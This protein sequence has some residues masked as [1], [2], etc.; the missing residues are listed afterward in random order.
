MPG[1]FLCGIFAAG[2]SLVT[3][4]V[5]VFARAALFSIATTCVHLE[6]AGRE[7]IQGL[8][9]GAGVSCNLRFGEV[10]MIR[11]IPRRR[12]L[13]FSVLLAALLSSGAA[14]AQGFDPSKV[15]WEALSKIPMRDSFIKNF[16]DD[17]ASCHSEDLRGTSLGPA[18]VGR[19][20]TFGDSVEQ[21]AALISVGSLRGGMPAWAETMN[22]SQIWNLALYVAEQRQGTTI[23]D[24]RADMPLVVP[25]G[26]LGS[27]LH[28]F[29]LETV[30]TGLDPLPFSIA[31]M[32]DGRI[33]LAERMRGLRIISADG[34]KSDYIDG[35]PAV[36][37]DSGIFLGQVQGLG[38]MLDVALHPQYAKNGWIYIHHTDRCSDCNDLSRK[39]NQP[40]SMNRIVRGRIKEGKWV[41]QEIIW[42]APVE[43]YTN[44]SDLAAG[45][46]LTFDAD[47]YVYFSIG[48]KDTL[49]FMGIQDLDLPY[50]KIH[51]VHADGR[52]PADNPF[53][54]TPGAMPSIWTYGHRSVQGLEFDPLTKDLWSTEMGPRGG[55]ELNR[56]VRGGNYGWP[57]FTTGVNYDGRP[58]NVAEKLGLTLTAEGAEFPVVDWTPAIAISS[59][60][61]YD[62]S[63]FPRWQ[64]DIIAGTLRATDLLRLQVVDG[65]VVHTEILIE[66]LARFRDVEFGPDGALYLLLE[67]AAGSQIIRMLPAESPAAK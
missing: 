36:Y 31:P 3:P 22:E 12:H 23:L 33:L 39:G 59:F 38:W 64:G 61:F 56:L 65:Q 17:C 43:T 48:M 40:V 26:V 6:V 5:G 2:A 54:D 42:Q 13:V 45:G 18:L 21:I 51:R 8:K 52:I 55:D 62:R 30:A 14:A 24:K 9:A 34:E 29:R 41:D 15:D 11:L 60:V 66:N 25:T 44:T 58:V 19:E 37:D 27:E 46:R 63:D 35:T 16:N 4:A 1:F 20:L 10:Q 28:S 50:G 47:G 49:D 32:P 67:N 57:V 53:V 7:M